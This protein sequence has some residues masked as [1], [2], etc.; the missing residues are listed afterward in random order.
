MQFRCAHLTGVL[1]LEPAERDLD[2]VA[3][4]VTELVVLHGFLALLSTWDADAYA[5]F[6]QRFS[7]PVGVLAAIPEKPIDIRH[8]AQQCPCAD[9]VADLTVGDVQGKGPPM[10]VADD[11]Q[12]GIHAAFGTADQAIAPPFSRP[13]W[14][15]FGGR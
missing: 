9:V 2:P 6:F 4:F 3:A 14:S 13:C 8:S 7:E 5:F 11:V 10:A 15:L 1:R 12:L